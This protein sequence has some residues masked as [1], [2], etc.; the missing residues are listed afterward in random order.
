MIEESIRASGRFQVEIK[1]DYKLERER[2]H[3]TYTIETYAFVPNSLDVS[4]ETYPKY[5]FYRD[6]QTYIRFKTPIALLS[7]IA[8]ADS[9]TFN[10]LEKSLK[11]LTRQKTDASVRDCENQIRQFCCIVKYSIKDYIALIETAGTPADAEHLIEYYHTNIVNILRRFRKLDKIVGLSSMDGRIRSIYALADEYSSIFITQYTFDILEKSRKYGD[12]NTCGYRK[13]LLGLIREEERYR[14]EKS[15][16]SVAIAG[17]NNEEFIYRRGVLKRMMESI[18]FLNT[19]VRPEGKVTEQ[20]IYSMAAGVAMVFA[21][22][23]AFLTQHKYG[24]FT[25]AFF[26][27]LVVSYMFKDRIKEL[28]R[29]YINEKVQGRYFDHKVHIYGGSGGNRLGFSRESFQ[30]ISEAGLQAE[31]S[32]LR[33]RDPLTRFNNEQLGEKVILYRKT[34]KIFSRNFEQVYHSIPVDGLTD[35]WRVNMARFV[36]KMDNPKKPLFVLDGKDYRKAK[37][38]KVYHINLVIRYVASHGEQYK[39]FRVV[40]NR[41]GIKRIEKIENI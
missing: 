41:S 9:N 25:L 18:L 38:S 15:Y 36:R 27:A 19:R 33:N 39:R 26:V 22:A 5:L 2:K 3:T 34:L 11:D 23:V 24:N 30:F 21:T 7:D 4:R 16:P 31:I 14:T 20:V 1:S 17:S 32:S 12:D 37:A 8:S 28:A 40:L 6:T 10:V 35:I 29:L 13:M